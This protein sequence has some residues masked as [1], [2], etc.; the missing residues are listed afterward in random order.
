MQSPN[1]D[2]MTRQEVREYALKHREDGEAVN[3]LIRTGKGKGTSYPYPRTEE[4]VEKITE[5]IKQ[6]IED[7]GTS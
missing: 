5:A 3:Y 6:K 2:E 1:F 4:D 7:L